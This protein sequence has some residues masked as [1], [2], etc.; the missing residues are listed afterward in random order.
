ME[1]NK[2]LVMDIISRL[3]V[4]LAIQC[5]IL[6]KS[7]N[8]KLCEPKVMLY[9]GFKMKIFLNKSSTH[10]RHQSTIYQK[11]SVMSQY[12][13]LQYPLTC[14]FWPLAR[15]SFFLNFMKPGFNPTTGAHQLIPYPE[16]RKK[17]IEGC[18]E[19]LVVDYPNSGLYKLVTVMNN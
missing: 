16:P 13:G 9:S 15:V 2:D 18:G 1:L 11:F 19:G 12:E 5:K 6:S 14:Q 3:P 17:I 8:N 4:K 7:I 10:H